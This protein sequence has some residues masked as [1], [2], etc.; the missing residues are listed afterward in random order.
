MP[1]TSSFTIYT[2]EDRDG[3]GA[4]NGLTGSLLRILNAC[5][6][7]GYGTGSYF[8]PAAGWSKP[9]PDS[10]STAGGFK[11]ASGSQF[12]MFVNDSAPTTGLTATE[13]SLVG[14]QYLSSSIPPAG[15]LNTGS[16]GTGYGQFPTPIQLLTFGHLVIRKSVTASSV[17]RQWILAADASTMYMWIQTGDNGSRYWHFGFGEF[18]SLKGPTDLWR[19]FIYGGHATG[20]ANN[21]C[22]T[23]SAGSQDAGRQSN[24]NSLTVGLNGHYLAANASGTG[25]SV[26]NAVKGD[27]GL[28]STSGISGTSNQASIIDGIMASP[29]PYDGSYYISPLWVV[30]PPSINIRGRYRGLYQICHPA[31]TFTVGQKLDGSGTYAGKTFMVITVGGNSGGFWGLEVSNTVETN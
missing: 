28:S 4:C 18:Y 23:M 26:F 11:Q 17:A 16:V 24:I 1:T 12:S 22:D 8:K 20:A 27:Q 15:I 3:P 6:I 31:T 7:N 13:A 21:W 25:G 30:E 19:C 5:L 14:W 10:A 29:N 2:S 9:C